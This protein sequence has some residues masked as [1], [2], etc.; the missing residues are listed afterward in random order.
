MEQHN[1]FDKAMGTVGTLLFGALLGAAAAL[2][3]APK[4]GEELRHDL[5]EEARRVS[6]QFG[7]TTETVKTKLNELSHHAEQAGDKTD[8]AEAEAN[9]KG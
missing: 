2:L 9:D 7:E 5:A 6:E 3:L 8:S 1:S 4:S